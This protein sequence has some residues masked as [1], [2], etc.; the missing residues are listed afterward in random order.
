MLLE[1][2][3][4]LRLINAEVYI[5]FKSRTFKVLCVIAIMLS[6]LLVGLSKLMSTEDF[7]KSNLKDMTPEQQEQYIKQLESSN[8]ENAPKVNIGNIGFRGDNKDISHPT[9]KEIFHG[10]FG[11]GLIEI[12]MA[13]LIGAMV[14]RE[15]SSGTI[16][17]IL[18]Y[19]KRREHYYISKLI[20]ITV[21]LIVILGIMVALTT[22]VCTRM[23]GWGEPFNIYQLLHISKVFVVA[24]IV[25]MAINSFLML[26]ATTVKSNGTTIGIGIV[27]LVLLPTIIA[28]LY[29]K[30]DWFDKI[31]E[32]TTTYNWA[33]ATSVRATNGDLLKAVII[34][35]LAVIIA[36]AGGIM[37]FKKQ[38]IK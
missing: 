30:Y 9:A 3:E 26:L 11:S 7:I 16:K 35:L 20:A 19:G 36:T 28:S 5:L 8:N 2:E 29:G 14:A 31:Y 10:S 12:L 21:G 33:L 24:I 18:A 1:V 6:L 15:Y 27:G 4:M 34:S 25:G 22:V 23:Y 32:A 13:V 17:N 37:I 38:D